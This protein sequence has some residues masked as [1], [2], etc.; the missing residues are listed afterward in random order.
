MRHVLAA[1][2]LLL[3]ASCAAPEKAKQPPA[4]AAHEP[5]A[6]MPLAVGN[7][8]TYETRFG[9]KV[10]ENTVRIEK[11]EGGFFRD[12]QRGAFAVDEKGNLRDERRFLIKA[13]VKAGTRWA[14]TV[15]VGKT[16]TYEIID[17][18]AAVTVPAGTF[19]GVL[20]VK[21]TTQVDAGTELEIVWAY[22][23]GVGLVRMLTTAV[24]GGRERVPQTEIVLKSH[25]VK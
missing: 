5:G 24:I 11:Q 8:W 2:C 16:E 1:V 19:H 22:A 6:Y 12:N 20:L 4:A 18:D 3:A 25:Q 21:G 14:S 10:E 15:D 7:S 9:K 17:T 13:P 23:P